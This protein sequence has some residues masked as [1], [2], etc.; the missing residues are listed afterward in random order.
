ML[1]NDSLKETNAETANDHQVHLRMKS[2]TDHLVLESAQ[3][4][5]SIHRILETAMVTKFALD[6]EICYA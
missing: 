5:P 4:H 1:P 6:H 3:D 2:A